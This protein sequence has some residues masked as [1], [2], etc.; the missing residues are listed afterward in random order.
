MSSRQLTPVKIGW[1]QDGAWQVKKG[2]GGVAAAAAGTPPPGPADSPPSFVRSP[3]QSGERGSRSST[4]RFNPV[5]LLA[6]V[7]VAVLVVLLVQRGARSGSPAAVAACCTVTAQ[8]VGSSG[9]GL[10]APVGVSVLSA[11]AESRLKSG[12]R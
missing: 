2:S 11:P 6:L 12:V 9:Q 8:L 10:S 5:W 4:N 1:S 3:K 7:V